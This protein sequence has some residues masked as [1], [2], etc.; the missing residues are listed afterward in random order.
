MGL[1]GLLSAFVSSMGLTGISLDTAN[2]LDRPNTFR[3]I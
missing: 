2:L 3:R 1:D